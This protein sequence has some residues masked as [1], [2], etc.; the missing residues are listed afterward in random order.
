MNVL[1]SET[2]INK[3]KRLWRIDELQLIAEYVA[4]KSGGQYGYFKRPRAN[5]REVFY[6]KTEGLKY[7]R[8][9]WFRV[10]HTKDLNNGDNYQIKVEPV[11]QLSGV[12]PYQLQLIEFTKSDFLT[13]REF[14]KKWF[15][16]KGEN[17]GDAAT[18]ASQLRLNELELYTQTERFIFELLQN[19]DDMPIEGKKVNVKMELLDD[20]F[21]FLHDGKFF[22]RNDVR[23]IADAAQ[24]T[25]SND[26][27][28]TGY[29]GIGFKSVFTDSTRVFIKS[30]DYSF[31][32]DKL[33]P[34][35]QDFW[36]LYNSYVNE[37]SEA[38]RE[39]IK[40]EY[41]G[42]EAEFTQIERIPW[43]IKPIW[44]ER[45]DFPDILKNSDFWS[46]QNV[47]IALEIGQVTFVE[48]Q[49]EQKIGNLLCEPRFLLFLR[50]I[51][52]VSYKHDDYVTTLAL[53]RSNA[54]FN[55]LLNNTQHSAYT[56]WEAEIEIS[57]ESF[58]NAGLQ[59]QKRALQEGKYEFIADDGQQIKNIP[60][61]LSI[62]D[63][64]TLTFA[65]HIQVNTIQRIA[66]EKA[67]L[68]NYLP[69]SDK[70]FR[71]P[72]L[73]NGD[74]V[75]KTDRE[76]ILHENVWNQ[77]LFFH[78][79]YQHVVWLSRL[80]QISKFQS[81]Y[82]NLL[83]KELKDDTHQAEGEING[84]LN[85]GIVKAIAELSF[86]RTESGQSEL[87]TNIILDDT[88][89]A[90]A[91]GSSLFYTL[92]RTS[93]K[94]PEPKIKASILRRDFLGI[95]RFE[96]EGLM[97][98]LKDE[99]SLTLLTEAIYA[100]SGVQYQTFLTW[101][102]T[103]CD[104]NP[105][106]VQPLFPNLP[107]LRFGDEV[108]SWSIVVKQDNYL[109]LDNR[110]ESLREELS[111]LGFILSD[112]N[113]DKTPTLKS[114][115]LANN[116]Y[117]DSDLLLYRKVTSSCKI[118]MLQPEHKSNLFT[119]F[120]ECKEVGE[121]K[122]AKS[123]CLFADDSGTCRQLDKLLSR[124]IDGLPAW[125][126]SYKINE[127]EF[128]V[129]PPLAGKYL[130][131]STNLFSKLLCD[132][133]V[134]A[135]CT[136]DLNSL[137]LT[138]WVY[139]LKTWRA[140]EDPRTLDSGWNA[141]PWLYTNDIARFMSASQLWN[142]KELATIPAQKVVESLTG[143]LI[144]HPACQ[145]LVS[146]FDLRLKL[147]KLTAS[148]INTGNV[149][150]EEETRL[151]IQFLHAAGENTFFE[152]WQF[153]VVETGFQ[154]TA[155]IKKTI[156]S[157]D[158][159]IHTFIKTSG[160]EDSLIAAPENLADHSVLANL[161]VL[162]GDTLLALLAEKAAVLTLAPILT[163]RADTRL[164]T[165]YLQ[166]ISV[167][168]L[169]SSVSYTDSSP[170]VHAL[171]IAHD[172]ADRHKSLVFSTFLEKITL[173]GQPLS[174]IK[175]FGAIVNVKRS[176]GGEP[177]KFSTAELL[178]NNAHRIE[179]I[180]GAVNAFTKCK[181]ISQRFLR[182]EIFASKE[183]R[184]DD[185]ESE[186][187]KSMPNFLSPQQLLF[188]QIHRGSKGEANPQFKNKNFYNYW[189]EKGDDKKAW[190][191]IGKY[192][193]LLYDKNL[194]NSYFVFNLDKF[195]ID[196]DYCFTSAESLP[197][198][199]I[200]WADTD[201]KLLFLTELNHGANGSNSPVVKLRKALLQADTAIVEIQ[202]RT[203]NNTLLINTLKWLGTKGDDY[204]TTA[205]IDCIRLILKKIKWS[206]DQ[207]PI[208]PIIVSVDEDKKLYRLVEFANEIVHTWSDN[209]KPYE[210][211]IITLLASEKIWLV[212]DDLPA[213][214]AQ[215]IGKQD[216]KRLV[217]TLADDILQGSV[218]PSEPCYKLWELKEKYPIYVIKGKLI[219]WQVWYGDSLVADLQE[220]ESYFDE[221][222]K[223]TY[224]TKD[225]ARSFPLNL[226][227]S[228]PLDQKATLFELKLQ[229]QESRDESIKTKISFGESRTYNVSDEA[230]QSGRE[231]S[232]DQQR[233]VYG[234][235]VQ[236]GRLSLE[237]D[238]YDFANAVQAEIGYFKNVK[239]PATD[240]HIEI[241]FRSAK[242][243][244]L[245]LN[246]GLWHRLDDPNVLLV[247][248]YADANPRYVM[249][250]EAL[251]RGKY[252]D[253]ILF[254]M[255]NGLQSD[256]IDKIAEQMSD[257]NGHLLFITGSEM[258]KNL[259]QELDFR[260][261]NPPT[262]SAL[263]DK[264]DL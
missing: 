194:T 263:G 51:T 67:I 96:V 132:P 176:V 163:E 2:V 205:N 162:T 253:Y 227:K 15:S 117:L 202:T 160:L 116:T 181:L 56:K 82:L 256:A 207:S 146:H 152:K 143:W 157:A 72:F 99:T 172:I 225:T 107:F 138:D 38:K 144:P 13:P 261:S 69:T 135:E 118:H 262:D 145:E 114:S 106:F 232:D 223:I 27:T 248:L 149:F 224:L 193:T 226:P 184:A 45:S 251:L 91:L 148:I 170:E 179:H 236:R 115:L 228:F 6:P 182:D 161:G 90:K 30:F 243:G 101:L 234:E 155:L 212:E 120:V 154:L 216:S 78:I 55:I 79:G 47:A 201:N 188:L 195:I 61:K 124:N 46:N 183:L 169:S 92:T 22:D 264:F 235:A 200:R 93:K 237:E 64:T 192:L 28:K 53:E 71:F 70:R 260:K 104:E 239:P 166:H 83:V 8:Q 173:D 76:F 10:L 222:T 49:Y 137:Q 1:D 42:R 185:A 74:F 255:M 139:H 102:N 127:E 231:L 100:F 244:L 57:N 60:E 134:L 62:L 210:G 186:I 39:E 136:R 84:A 209:W 58:T 20:Y 241:Y 211:S 95:E 34:V 130:I 171:R 14:I 43:Q 178:P 229:L 109:L 197:D 257:T 19:A 213:E 3:L 180:V 164:Y 214:V 258:Y 33:H 189:H 126:E 254:R 249:S 131:Q 190:E 81:S 89:L 220:G 208:I 16:R 153:S 196:P 215:L 177:Y 23:A 191:E 250:K 175:D 113:V 147:D 167:L 36:Q 9:V 105:D 129:L 204:L 88:G 233:T 252:N 199:F 11:R 37:S 219:P 77:Y 44:V 25:K 159:K 73:V 97:D 168:S 174:E 94:L 221:S 98:L 21:L 121:E 48:K 238:G 128:K 122:Y 156:Y 217:R 165:T 108:V 68:F 29:K 259:S 123:L 119:F 65:A 142:H 50:N 80:S 111:A 198:F 87:C 52:S 12:N 85:R 140:N 230:I 24:S 246:P 242:G 17:P 240:A 187:Y 31:K 86:I 125:L 203:V 7:D 54:Q 218:P 35:Y 206:A 110:T 32:F 26:K 5:D 150:S 158:E 245:Y 141:L 112:I 133:A 66:E 63:R 247:V 103:L 4:P 59:F 18:I 40:R 75:T 151:F 41:T